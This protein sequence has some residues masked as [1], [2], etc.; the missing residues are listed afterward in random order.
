M[1]YNLVTPAQG[2]SQGGQGLVHQYRAPHQ[3]LDFREGVA[4][5]Y[6]VIAAVSAQASPCKYYTC[7]WYIHVYTCMYSPS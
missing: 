3:P 5:A 7:T 4:N 1:V 2:D 6:D